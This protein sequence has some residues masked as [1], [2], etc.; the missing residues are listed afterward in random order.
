MQPNR[1]ITR[2]TLNG[3]NGPG[4]PTKRSK[5]LVSVL[6]DALA[7]RMGFHINLV[8][9]VQFHSCFSLCDEQIA[10]RTTA[11]RIVSFDGRWMIECESKKYPEAGSSATF[12]AT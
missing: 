4:R 7:I 3:L 11:E 12:A 1:A 9:L 6:L 5:K 2:P 10:E 8:R